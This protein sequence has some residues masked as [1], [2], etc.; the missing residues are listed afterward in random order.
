MSWETSGGESGQWDIG[1]ATNTFNDNASASANG[2]GGGFGG[3]GGDAVEASGGF[4]GGSRGAC[5]NCGEE[6]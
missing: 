5:F 1:A 4:G 6:G 3:E 2:F